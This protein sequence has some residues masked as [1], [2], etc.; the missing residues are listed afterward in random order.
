MICAVI[1]DVFGTLLEITERTN[2]YK[3]LLREGAVQGRCAVPNDLRFL[4]TFHGGLSEAADALKIK[5]T[6]GKLAELQAALEIEVESI[7]LYD[8]A[9][10]A[11][12]MLKL[13]GLRLGLCSN[14]A[15][16]YC[17]KV[18]EL[19]PQMDG[20]ALSCE[21]G[22]MKPD[23]RIYKAACDLL[24]VKSD[25]VAGTAAN[26]VLMIGDSLKCDRDGPKEAGI[27]GHHLNRRGNGPFVDLLMFART[28]TESN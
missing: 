23:P 21:L 4:M 3:S 13:R 25:L 24:A 15:S 28:V 10:P 11:L 18:R 19:L 22:V 6:Q 1:L 7:R 17:S 9:L 12:D 5:V 27:I 14:L 20:Y 26:Q 2:P 8:D 16:A